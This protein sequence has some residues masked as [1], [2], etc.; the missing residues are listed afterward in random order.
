MK[1]DRPP[2]KQPRTEDVQGAILR[3]IQGHFY[4]G[5]ALAFAKDRPRLLKWVVWK[6]ASYLDEKAVTIPGDRYIEIMLVKPGILMEALRFGDTGNI[7]YLPA[8]LGKVV[9][10][11]LRIHGE[12]Y[13]TEGKALRNHL[14][15]ALTIAHRGLQ[16]RDPVRE[17]AEAARLLKP[18]KKPAVKPPSKAQLSLFK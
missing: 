12:D 17:M 2:K 3:F 11:H 4:Q 10:S 6:L 8:W 5:Q 18:S 1:S 14:E 7:T 9:E 13:Y 16:G 15:G